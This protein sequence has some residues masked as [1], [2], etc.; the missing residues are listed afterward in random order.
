MLKQTYTVPYRALHNL[1]G[2]VLRSC[3]LQAFCAAGN[4]STS[5]PP[6]LTLHAPPNRNKF[7]RLIHPSYTHITTVKSIR[8]NR[9]VWWGRR[10]WE[11]HYT[12]RLQ[13]LLSSNADAI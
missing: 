1:V 8:R 4:N 9:G 10:H 6:P 2:K 12:R 7:T 3:A 5:R 11:L 13:I